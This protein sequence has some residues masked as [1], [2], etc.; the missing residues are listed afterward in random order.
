[1]TWTTYVPGATVKEYRPLPLVLVVF[2]LLLGLEWG[3][4]RA[5]GMV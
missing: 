1:M 2:V 5:W 4:R 3:L